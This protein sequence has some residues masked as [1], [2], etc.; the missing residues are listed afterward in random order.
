MAN[1]KEKLYEYL[2]NHIEIR[3]DLIEKIKQQP[4][5][6]LDFMGGVAAWYKGSGC[7]NYYDECRHAIEYAGYRY[8]DSDRTWETAESEK[9]KVVEH[10]LAMLGYF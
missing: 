10:K 6:Q 2:A 4:Q 9:N 7:S 3:L 8:P 5:K 1:R